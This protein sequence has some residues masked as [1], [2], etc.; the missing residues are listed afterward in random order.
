MGAVYE[1]LDNELNVPVALKVIRPEIT[2]DPVAARDLARRFK[3][4]LL[5]ARQVTNKHVVRIHDLGE[6]DGIKYLTMTYVEGA[7]LS[8]VLRLAGRLELATALRLARQSRL[9]CRLRT[10]PGSCTGT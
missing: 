4:E 9:A 5:L 1:A 7:D 2:A 10:R 3:L 8:T 6:I